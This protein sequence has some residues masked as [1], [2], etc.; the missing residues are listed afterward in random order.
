MI[1]PMRTFGVCLLAVSMAACTSNDN[2]SSS[3]DF[4]RISFHHDSVIV[5]SRQ[6]PPAVLLRDGSLSIEGET[7]V[8]T[9]AQQQLL[10]D[11]YRQS[12][13]LRDSGI[14]VG[15][16]G[17]TMA[18]HA[19]GAVV[20]GLASGNPE[21]IGPRVEAQ[22]AKIEARVAELC[23]ELEALRSTQQAI[24]AEL[25]AFL[26]YATISADDVERCNQ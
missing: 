15:A 10:A 7:I 6:A 21:Q 13:Q 14:A 23:S 3:S 11:Y 19:I 20:S 2:S 1:P 25:P 4:N 22:V 12:V 24:A 16:A 5:H 26:P 9:A 8:A 18:G 17:G